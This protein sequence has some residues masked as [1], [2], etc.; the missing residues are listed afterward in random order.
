MPGLSCIGGL[1]A[2][3]GGNASAMTRQFRI[4][5]AAGIFDAMA[6]LPAVHDATAFLPATFDPVLSISLSIEA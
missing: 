5:A 4:V 2:G 3:S 1:A 6:S